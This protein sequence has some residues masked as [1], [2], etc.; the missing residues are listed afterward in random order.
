MKRGW[1]APCRGRPSAGECPSPSPPAQPV[2]LQAPGCGPSCA[3]AHAVAPPPPAIMT[4]AEGSQHGRAVMGCGT[5]KSSRQ[6]NSRPWRGTHAHLQELGCRLLLKLLRR[7]GHK[8]LFSLH[9]IYC[10]AIKGHSCA[11][12]LRGGRR[13]VLCCCSP[14]RPRCRKACT[15]THHSCDELGAY[16]RMRRK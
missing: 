7:E 3:C 10:C 14:W 12:L 15:P 5:E 11:L 8:A 4:C 1:I 9:I 13:A 2:S 16:R 6:T